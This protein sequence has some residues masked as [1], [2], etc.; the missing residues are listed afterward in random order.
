MRY[1]LLAA[2]IALTAGHALAGT[3]ARTQDIDSSIRPG[4]DF[5]RYANG[6]WLKTTALPDGLAAYGSSAML[7]AQN[8]ARV[9]ALIAAA[10]SA[11]R[12]DLERKIGDYYAGWMDTAGIEARGVTPLSGDLAA[13]AAIHDRVSLSAWLGANVR[14]DDGTNSATDGLFGIWIHQ[15]F[16]DSDRYVPHMVQG[17]LGLGD[18]DAYLDLSADAQARRDTYRTHIAAVLT[19]AGLDDAEAR[20][21]RVL[22]LEAA[23][24]QT[25]ATAEDIADVA[26]TDNAWRRDDFTTKAPGLDWDAYFGGGRPGPAG[27]LRRLATFGGDGDLGIDR[28]PAG[29]DVAGLSRLSPCRALCR[30]AAESLRRH[31]GRPRGAGDR[32]HQRSL[33]RGR[34]PALCGAVFSATGQGDGRSHGRQYPHRLCRAHCRGRL[35]VGGKRAPNPWTNWQR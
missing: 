15:G 13:I 35:D 5:Y 16:H 30:R 11:P 33:G 28:Q 9:R 21:G 32:C 6:S 7:V 22:A 19:L 10:A 3:V 4:D 8:N 29:R 34:R 27:R 25:H 12:N 26:K 31:A 14:T 18:R 1:C 20:A 24:A 2:A 23:I 17:G